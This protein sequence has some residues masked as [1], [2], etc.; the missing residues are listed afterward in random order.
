[1]E[2]EYSPLGIRQL[3]MST[4]NCFTPFRSWDSPFRNDSPGNVLKSAA[5]TF[6]WTPSI[7]RKRSRDLVSPLSQKR[8]EKRLERD[9]NEESFS[10][11]AL[12]FSRLDVMFDENENKKAPQLSSKQREKA[13]NFTSNKENL[14]HAGVGKEEGR[15][16]TLGTLIPEKVFD[17]SNPE[18]DIEQGTATVGAKSKGHANVATHNVSELVASYMEGLCNFFMLLYIN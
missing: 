8:S 10:S 17:S 1:M 16:S 13:G 4:M 18:E 6:T 15:D 14:D 11:L 5:K 12:N 9:M 3:M 2:Q 7:L